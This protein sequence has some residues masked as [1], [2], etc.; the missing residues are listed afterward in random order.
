MDTTATNIVFKCFET[1]S[2]VVKRKEILNQLGMDSSKATSFDGWAKKNLR[3]VGRGLYTL[4]DDEPTTSVVVKHPVKNTQRRQRVMLSAEEKMEIATIA[5]TEMLLRTPA[6][7]AN[8]ASYAAITAGCH[9]TPRLLVKVL[10]DVYDKAYSELLNRL[11]Q[12]KPERVIVEKVPVP[13]SEYSTI[14]LIGELLLR[15]PSLVP[16]LPSLFGI[17][18]TPAT[19]DKAV[20]TAP[21]DPNPARSVTQK[22]KAKEV[23]ITGLLG[24]QKMMFLQRVKISHAIRE[25]KLNLHFLEQDKKVAALPAT[26]DLVIMFSKRSHSTWTKLC[27]M[28]GKDNVTEAGGQHD[29]ENQ[30]MK[31]IS[32]SH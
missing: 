9:Q 29:M 10:Q 3:L 13:L 2:S 27:A 17:S 24:R 31:L 18:N 25:D 11:I 26:I 19:P 1:K 30:L 15:A 20:D 5:A 23:L 16:K 6:L 21:Q 12:E 32:R 22:S 4:L 7:D 8:V 28:Y 14:E